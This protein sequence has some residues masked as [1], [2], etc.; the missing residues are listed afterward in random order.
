MPLRVAEV[1]KKVK[2]EGE[3]NAYR[4]HLTFLFPVWTNFGP[5]R[6][7]D[8]GHN[9]NPLPIGRSKGRVTD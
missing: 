5:L 7:T 8:G 9:E 6:V 4:A 3:G 2:M 1:G